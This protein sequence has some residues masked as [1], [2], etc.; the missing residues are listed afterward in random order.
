MIKLKSGSQISVAEGNS[1]K[2]S[3]MFRRLK[4]KT[5]NSST[6]GIFI[7]SLISI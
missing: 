4:G 3:K 2:M 7:P 5:A 1:C 6:L